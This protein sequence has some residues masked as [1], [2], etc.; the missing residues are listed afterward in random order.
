MFL[1][2]KNLMDLPFVKQISFKAA[3]EQQVLMFAVFGL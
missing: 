1:I 3:A 2:K